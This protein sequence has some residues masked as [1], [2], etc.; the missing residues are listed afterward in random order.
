MI[1]SN[2]VPRCMTVIAIVIHFTFGFY[3]KIEL[4]STT[5]KGRRTSRVTAITTRF[6]TTTVT[7]TSTVVT[8]TSTA[9]SKCV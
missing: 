7:S 3:V 2:V 6:T 1:I 9:M 4:I 8:S 5:S